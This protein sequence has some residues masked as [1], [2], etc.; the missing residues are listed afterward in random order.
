MMRTIFSPVV[1]KG[2]L[3]AFMILIL[4]YPFLLR[5]S[6][7]CRL[8]NVLCEDDCRDRSSPSHFVVFQPVSGSHKW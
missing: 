6:R 7:I 2:E 4:S 5:S 1:A 8:F 3:E